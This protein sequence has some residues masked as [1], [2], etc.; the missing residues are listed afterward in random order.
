[1]ECTEVNK[2]NRQMVFTTLLLMNTILLIEDNIE[3]LENLT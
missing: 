2:Q 3:F 1:M